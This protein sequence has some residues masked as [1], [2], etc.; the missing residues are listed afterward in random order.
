LIVFATVPGAGLAL[1]T[2]FAPA[3]SVSFEHSVVM[4]SDLMLHVPKALP[5]TSALLP[6]PS[7]TL[8]ILQ[9]G[10]FVEAAVAALVATADKASTASRAT[11]AVRIDL[12]W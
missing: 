6:L 12:I 5:V 8:L 4:P 3:D 10:L 9:S 1:P 2:I 11:S 7:W